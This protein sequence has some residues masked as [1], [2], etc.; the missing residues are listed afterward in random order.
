MRGFNEVGFCFIPIT[1]FGVEY[2][3]IRQPPLTNKFP[4]VLEFLEQAYVS[5]STAPVIYN[6][7]LTANCYSEIV[8][9]LYKIEKGSV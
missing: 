1:V 9:F 2:M 6:K 5:K 4:P 3:R 7:T 8:P